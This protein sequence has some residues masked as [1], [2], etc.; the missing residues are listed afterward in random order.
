MSKRGKSDAREPA[1]ADASTPAELFEAPTIPAQPPTGEQA[2][3]SST[4]PVAAT[5]PGQGE[6]R[7]ETTPASGKQPAE[8]GE[9][10]A[11]TTPAPEPVKIVLHGPDGQAKE[12]TPEELIANPDLLRRMGTQ[13]EQQRHFQKLSED[14]AAEVKRL[15]AEKA[16]LM[17]RLA[18]AQPRPDQP[19]AQPPPFSI[20]KWREEIQPTVQHLVKQGAL[21]EETVELFPELATL[22]AAL[23]QSDT[24][25]SLDMVDFQNAVL[26]VYNKQL[27][28]LFTGIGQVSEQQ[29]VE[30]FVH[31]VHRD[32]ESLASKGP[33]FE[34]LKDPGTR[35][36]FL[37]YLAQRVNP[38]TSILEGAD[39]LDFLEAQFIAFQRDPIMKALSEASAA[40][41]RVAETQRRT[42]PGET[43]GARAPSA[44][45][46]NP[47]I[48]EVFAKG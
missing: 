22:V 31:K 19:G 4:T 13:A 33:F 2:A 6:E 8:G 14:R 47:D 26:Q 37:N 12:Y 36:T 10:K 32:M 18:P 7:Q 34:S 5:E 35:E 46:G 40:K 23:V 25:R 30:G 1:M 48:A 9:G 43:G 15:E 38:E 42:A 21:S 45:V 28:P 17:T 11:P 39:A 29:Q 3:E 24:M 41:M 27:L 20:E 44:P 16:E